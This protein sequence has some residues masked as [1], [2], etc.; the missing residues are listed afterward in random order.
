M[1]LSSGAVTRGHRRRVWSRP[2]PPMPLPG[3]ACASPTPCLYHGA[4]CFA[5][6]LA[7]T[8]PLVHLMAC[9]IPRICIGW[10]TIHT[11]AAWSA[12]ARPP[13]GANEGDRE[14]SPGGLWAS[15]TPPIP[16]SCGGRGA[17]SSRDR[18]HRHTRPLQHLDGDAGGGDQEGDGAE[19][20]HDRARGGLV[21]ER[22]HRGEPR[23]GGIRLVEDALA[24]GQQG[25]EDGVLHVRQEE[26]RE[27][28]PAWPL[29]TT[30][31]G[32]E[33]GPPEQEGRRDKTQVLDRVP[34]WRAEGQLIQR[35]Y[36]PGRAGED[37]GEP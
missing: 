3:A 30:W 37:K 12:R 34:A 27:Q 18:P 7:S 20:P 8:S 21:V 11:S 10:P 33:H 6:Y 36:V 26:I 23:G 2:A 13:S 24:E 22:R 17:N 1:V 32:L 15:P 35:G 5:S 14:Q 25:G 31:P 4:S 28:H 19:H 29:R 16:L 9:I